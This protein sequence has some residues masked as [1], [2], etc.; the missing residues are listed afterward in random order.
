MK[1]GA[2]LS[3]CLVLFMFPVFGKGYAQTGASNHIVVIVNAASP[4]TTLSRKELSDLY[5]GRTRALGSMKQTIAIDQATNSP[6]RAQFYQNLT[7]KNIAEIN[8]YWARLLF[9]GQSSPPQTMPDSDTVLDVVRKNT[10]AVG[11]LNFK[12]DDKSIRVVMTLGE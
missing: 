4:V 9:A 10:T 6:V 3:L 1:S 12:P 5:L 7:G 2:F 11:Y 8:S